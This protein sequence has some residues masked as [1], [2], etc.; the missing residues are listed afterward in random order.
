M[1]GF[2]SPRG[3]PASVGEAP[4]MAIS[5]ALSIISS[6]LSRVFTS[7]LVWRS[8]ERRGFEFPVPVVKFATEF[9]AKAIPLRRRKSLCDF[10]EA[11][12]GL[13]P[14][15]APFRLLMLRTVGD[16]FDRWTSAT[17]KCRCDGSEQS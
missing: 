13:H 3:A 4:I 5:N 16:G 1:L 9:L 12:L 7:S 11:F 2:L 17:N 14:S 10:R 15:L 8:A 6:Y